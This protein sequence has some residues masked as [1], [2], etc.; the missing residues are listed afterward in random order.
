MRRVDRAILDAANGRGVSTASTF[1][2]ILLHHAITSA[3]RPR[4]HRVLD[5]GCGR[6]PYRDLFASDVY[7]GLDRGELGPHASVVG[8]AVE[9]P[10]ADATFD[11]IICTEVIEHVP[12]ERELARELARVAERSTT[13]IL[14]S[15]FVHGVHEQPYDFRRLTSIGLF[16][17]LTDAGWEVVHLAPVGG[18]AVVAIDSLVRWVDPA[19]RRFARRLPV[20]GALAAVAALSRRFQRALA[21]A[22]LRSRLSQFGPIAPE[23]SRPRLTLGY[24]VSARR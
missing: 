5:V 21:A 17:T 13:L 15:P 7:V 4:A 23:A 9:L 18:P 20:P 3:P 12:D 8:D 24:V 19:L 22:V 11:G 14:S 10:F 6:S 2:T 16:R 1:S